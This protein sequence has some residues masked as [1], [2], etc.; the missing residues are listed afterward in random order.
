PSFSEADVPHRVI[1]F[2]SSMIRVR[3]LELI[4]R[5][6]VRSTF[7]EDAIEAITKSFGPVANLNEEAV[8]DREFSEFPADLVIRPKI[9]EGIP[10]AVYFVNTNDKLNE[11][12]LLQ[13]EAQ[14]HNRQDFA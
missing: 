3:D 8:V 2:I 5:E 9:A 13:T 14:L 1:E 12:L 4:T 10:G 7:R 11:A 6:I